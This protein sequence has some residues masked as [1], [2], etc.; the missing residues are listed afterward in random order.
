METELFPAVGHHLLQARLERSAGLPADR[1]LNAVA[2][3]HPSRDVFIA[4]THGDRMGCKGQGILGTPSHTVD[5]LGKLEHRRFDRVSDVV[6]PV[7][8]RR[9]VEQTK[10]SVVQIVDI[11]EAAGMASIAMDSQRLSTQCGIHEAIYDSISEPWTVAV[12]DSNRE[13]VQLAIE[14]TSSDVVLEGC[15][16]RGIAPT[17]EWS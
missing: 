8:S 11:G 4:V 7:V 2:V 12:E 6:D 1:L 10:G 3:W 16:G 5:G 17:I 15:L 14:V 13:I 9:C